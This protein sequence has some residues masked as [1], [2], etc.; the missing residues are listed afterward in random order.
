MSIFILPP[1]YHALRRKMSLSQQ[2]YVRFR[3]WLFWIWLM[4]LWLFLTLL[5]SYK[6]SMIL[7]LI[8]YCSVRSKTEQFKY[9]FSYF[10]KYIL[11]HY[12]FSLQILVC[13]RNVFIKVF[14]CSFINYNKAFLT[15]T[16][17]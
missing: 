7:F 14:F 12:T 2:V 9:F 8:V 17:S 3:S 16:R 4:F 11:S 10:L 6:P 15:K 1:P 13:A 5:L